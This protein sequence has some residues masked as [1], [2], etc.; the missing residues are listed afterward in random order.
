MTDKMG[1]QVDQLEN[2]LRQLHIELDEL[3]DEFRTVEKDLLTLK[4][5]TFAVSTTV[6][7]IVETRGW[8][9]KAM[10]T[11]MVAAV[12]AWVTGGGLDS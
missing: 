7:G 4:G 8:A 1:Y 10:V 12:V 2:K 9:F 11:V 5:T 6:D 3:H